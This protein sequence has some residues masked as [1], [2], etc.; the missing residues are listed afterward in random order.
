MGLK[1]TV[2]A[3]R[4]LFNDAEPEYHGEL[5]DF[6]PVWF[7]PKPIQAGGPPMILGV[8]GPLG[9]RHAAEWADG[10]MPVDVA[11]P[12]VEQGIKD[13]RQQVTDFGRNPDDVEITMVAMG[14]VTT[15]L[16]KRYQD[17]GI[18]RVN[19]GVGMENWEKPDIVM[20]MIEEFSKL[21]PALK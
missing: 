17:M 20:P 4:N 2:L 5:V 21:I 9:V 13:F 14:Q 12:D 6:D 18:A 10:W 11:M 3:Q 16:L 19:I 15:D 8:M 7:E 1:E